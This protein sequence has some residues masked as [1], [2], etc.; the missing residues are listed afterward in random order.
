MTTAPATPARP[1][2]EPTDKSNPAELI[3]NVE[4]IA[5]IPSTDVARSIFRK[6]EMLKK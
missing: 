6:F 5:Q 4:P 1:I 2:T 3:T